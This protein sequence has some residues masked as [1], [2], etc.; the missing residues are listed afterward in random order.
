MERIDVL[1]MLVELRND[2]L[3]KEE[4]VILVDEAIR[5]SDSVWDPDEMKE[6]ELPELSF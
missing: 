6:T 5:E 4:R 3:E 2:G 1:R